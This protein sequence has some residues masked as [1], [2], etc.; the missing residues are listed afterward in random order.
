[1]T[2]ATYT[3]LLI[4]LDRSGS[5]SHIRNDMVGGLENMLGDHAKGDGLLTVDIVTFDEQIERTHHFANP[6]DIKIDLTP[7]G[8]TALYD[9]LGWSIHTFGADLASLPDH[10]RPS[11]VQVIVVTDGY[12]NASVE[13]RAETVRELITRQIQE[14]D[15]EFVYLG[16][17]QDAVLTASELG[18]DAGNALDFD[19]DGAAVSRMSSIMS[20]R[21]RRSRRGERAGFTE[22]ER[23]ASRKDDN[24]ES[25]GARAS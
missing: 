10:A 25:S 6:A 20:E 16:A 21:L 12:E 17:N 11:T 1:M 7:R 22:F 9:A 23:N 13:F 15:W 5:M 8:S 19:I 2:D 4:V 24:D 18:I 14:F 3:A